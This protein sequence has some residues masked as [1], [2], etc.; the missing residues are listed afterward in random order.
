MEK[1]KR[2]IIKEELV[3]L[4]GDGTKALILQQLIYWTETKKVS[5]KMIDEEISIA[6]KHINFN[7]KEI[8]EVLTK[9][10]IY[11][12][13]EELASEI[14]L[15]VS[16]KTILR[17]LKVLIEKGYVLQRRNPTFKYDRTFQYRV[18][19]TF[20]NQELNKLGYVLEGY[21]IPE[22]SND[23]NKGQFDPSKKQYLENFNTTEKP[24]NT[25]KGQFDPLN[26]HFDLLN[27]QNVRTIPETT[28]EITTETNLS[29]SIK[30]AKQ[31]IDMIDIQTQVKEKETIKTKI[32]NNINYSKLIQKLD[33]EFLDGIV[34][35]IVDVLICPNERI[36]INKFEQP[37]E[38]V[39][40]QFLKLTED[41][42]EY[43]FYC[44]Q[45]TTQTISN[46]KN[47]VLTALY[48][49]LN[50]KNIHIQKIANKNT[51]DKNSLNTYSGYKTS[52]DIDEYEKYSIFD[53]ETS[54]QNGT[55]SI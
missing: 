52:Y 41:H 40:K 31:M 42:I 6:S 9:G 27:S 49:S 8:D 13:S 45:K 18:N 4:T 51:V 20:I 24:S 33:E 44:L 21:A 25:N 1:L 10:W 39:K 26:F 47:Y 16:A 32:K 34:N 55:N 30:T 53:D 37:T 38:L 54:L 17:N 3:E 50:T 22:K 12:K 15:G 5:D 28:T 48:N 46:T 14:M 29:K 43:V 7:E 35:L 11:K 23:T 36:R 2:A 19:L